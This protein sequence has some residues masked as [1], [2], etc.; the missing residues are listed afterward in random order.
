MKKIVSI[1]LF[2]AIF[3]ILINAVVINGV[4]Y[5]IDTKKWLAIVTSRE[6]GTKYVGEITIPQAVVYNGRFNRVI[7]VDTAAF[8]ECEELTA[9]SLPGNV[10]TIGPNAFSECTSLKSIE[11]ANDTAYIDEGAFSACSAL[12]TIKLPKSIKSIA[13]SLFLNCSSLK[14]IVIP[15][16]ATSIGKSAFNGCTQ[17]STLTLGAA[18]SRIE[19]SAFNGCDNLQTIYSDNVTPPFCINSKATFSATIFNTCELIVPAEGI[20]LYKSATVWKNFVNIISNASINDIEVDEKVFE[21]SRYDI[22]GRQ[23][24]HPTQGI[25]IIKLSNGKTKKEY[26]K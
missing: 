1:I 17:L 22:Y 5:R 24:S 26:V 10:A 8:K 2:S 20:D 6:D 3:P 21:V 14:S 4:E 12:D 18:V 11:I 23:L 15:S 25:N 19:S 9:I 16:T 13:S 7:A